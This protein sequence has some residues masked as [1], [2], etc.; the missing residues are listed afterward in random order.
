LETVSI[1]GGWYP[2]WGPK[3]R[4]ELYSVAPSADNTM[5]VS[6]I[7]NCLASVDGPRP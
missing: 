6:L 1:N 5:S 4:D 7:L 2:R 3:G